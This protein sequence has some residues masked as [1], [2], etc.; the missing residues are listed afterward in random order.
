MMGGANAR[1]GRSDYLV[2]ESDESD[3]SFLKLAPII[4]V[5]TNIDREHLDHY[6]GIEEIREAFTQ[7]I[8]KVPFYGAAILCLDD[9]NIQQ[10]LPAVTRRTITYGVSAQAHLRVTSSTAGH[11][12]SEFHLHYRDRD[13]GCFRLRIPGAHNVLN[14][15]AAVAV[16]LE[17]EIPVDAIREALADFSGVDRRFQVRGS[18]RGIT[19]IDDY[20]HHP[21]EI[22]ATL[23]SAR[24]CRF[25][26]VHVLFQPHRYTRTQALMDDFARAFH[27]A[28]TVQVADIYAA[29]ELPIPGVTSEA[30]V[31]RLRAM[32]HRGAE[33]AG[34]LDRGISAVIAAASPG[35][36]ILTLG[37]GSVS[38]AA[39]H[40]LAQLRERS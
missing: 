35:D 9:E 10:I 24:A 8:G 21:T 23:A 34:P 14:A 37:A 1:L 25:K 39:D 38:Q 3:G 33:Y 18:E 31:E 22:R 4:A 6:S 17:L 36:V 29:S 32:G 26:A 30:L 12:A 20:G 28:D 15:T 11:M 40:I 27:Q 13:L 19:V 16:G 5:V 7:F 2:V